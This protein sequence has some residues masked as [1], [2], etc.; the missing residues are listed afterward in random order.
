[1]QMTSWNGNSNPSSGQAGITKWNGFKT[2]IRETFFN[3]W[4]LLKLFQK[5]IITIL[6]NTNYKIFWIHKKILLSRFSSSNI[7]SA[8]VWKRFLICLWIH[9]TKLIYKINIHNQ[10][11][12]KILIIRGKCI[13]KTYLERKGN[14][15]ALYFSS[16]HAMWGN[17]WNKAFK[18]WSKKRIPF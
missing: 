1:M 5:N 18:I 6:L 7:K 11:Y 3:F 4:V 12:L 8:S 14:W 2:F 13:L 9:I 16:E 17:K 10:N 15:T